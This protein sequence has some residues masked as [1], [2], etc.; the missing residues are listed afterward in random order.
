[1]RISRERM[2]STSSPSAS[3]CVSGKRIELAMRIGRATRTRSPITA[4]ESSQPGWMSAEAATAFCW[5][6][7]AR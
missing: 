7:C 3:T 2:Q 6:I 1:M 4:P 5:P